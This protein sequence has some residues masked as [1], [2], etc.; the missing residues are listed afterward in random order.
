MSRPR[1]QSLTS[2]PQ[3]TTSSS[4]NNNTIKLPKDI[5]T[6]MREHIN[7]LTRI[8]S[9]N[10][11]QLKELS[12]LS[13]DINNN[14]KSILNILKETQNKLK[15]NKEQAQINRKP[16]DVIDAQL[17]LI[18]D[19]IKEIQKRTLDIE[20][21]TNTSIRNIKAKLETMNKN[22]KDAEAS[23]SPASSSRQVERGVLSRMTDFFRG[24]QES[25]EQPPM[26]PVYDPSVLRS[27][28]SGGSK[29]IK[30]HTKSHTKTYKKKNINKNH[31]K[32]INKNYSTKRK[33]S[34]K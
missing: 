30:K 32:H 9:T 13:D 27:N 28:L 17:S 5:E 14:I 29:V 21:D 25:Q 26:N 24:S 33:T 8:K 7:N 3:P 23:S 15:Q 20:Q 22:L 4:Q 18:N 34:K 2:I 1:S 11:T 31:K 12:D 16:T 10:F 19:L 6:F